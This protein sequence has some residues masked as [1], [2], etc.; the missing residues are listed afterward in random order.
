MTNGF[1]ANGSRQILMLRDDVQIYYNGADEL[2]LRKGVWNFEEAILTF[3]ALSKD[4]KDTLVKIFNL[5]QDGTGV[6]IQRLPND[7]NSHFESE[8]R[9]VWKRAGRGSVGRSRHGRGGGELG[10]CERGEERRGRTCGRGEWVW[11]LELRGRWH[12]WWLRL[13][14]FAG[15]RWH[16]IWGG[17]GRGR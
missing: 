15:E 16:G 9:R 6:D 3:E 1:K 4:H 11:R 13:R 8:L 14:R 17:C 7:H 10:L 5:L 12:G 2:R